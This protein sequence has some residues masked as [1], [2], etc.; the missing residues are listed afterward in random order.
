MYRG[1]Q[2]LSDSPSAVLGKAS[3]VPVRD[4]LTAD[5][6]IFGA[7]KEWCT[8]SRFCGFSVQNTHLTAGVWQASRCVP[9]LEQ[10]PPL[11]PSK[12]AP[13]SVSASVAAVAWELTVVCEQDL[14]LVQWGESIQLAPVCSTL[15][16]RAAQP[17]TQG[18]K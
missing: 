6:A 13:H 7:S 17:F 8:A 10:H 2:Q 9:L 15:V 3:L 11:C 14:L 16:T 4:V 12:S 5:E 1:S 18:H